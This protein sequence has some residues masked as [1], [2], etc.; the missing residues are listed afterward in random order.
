LSKVKFVGNYLRPGG[1]TEKMFKVIRSNTEIALTPPRIV[2]LRANL[3]QSYITLQ[4]IGCK[5]SR[6]KVKGQGHGVK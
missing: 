6:S 5:C 2:R 4:A 3:A 1:D